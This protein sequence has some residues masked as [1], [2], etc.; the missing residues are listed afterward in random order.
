MIQIQMTEW[1]GYTN[2][3]ESKK[4]PKTA[5]NI[6]ILRNLALEQKMAMRDFIPAFSPVVLVWL[7]STRYPTYVI[8]WPIQIF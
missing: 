6:Q 4:Y 1:F 7:S 2:I 8:Q 3:L 5:K